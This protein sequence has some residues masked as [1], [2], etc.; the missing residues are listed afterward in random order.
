MPAK[1][2]M[3]I[4]LAPSKS[5]LSFFGTL[6]T[7]AMFVLFLA[8]GWRFA[9]SR[10]NWAIPLFGATG[11][12]LG[13]AQIMAGDSASLYFYEIT[14]RGLPVGV[15]ANPNHQACFLLMCL[16]FVAALIGQLR[17][18]W[19]S[20]DSDHA[21]AI[22][23]AAAA[24]LIL[25]GILATGSVAGY[26]ML[27]PVLA[28]CVVLAR[29]PRSSRR[30]AIAFPAIVI[31][32]T[33]AAVL[34]VAF[35]PLLDGL[36]VTSFENSDLSRLG[37]W[38]VTMKVVGDHWLAGTGLGSFEDVYRLYENPDTVTEKYVN[39][40]HNDY[41]QALVEFGLP[42]IAILLTGVVLV[43]VQF[44]RVWTRR[45]DEHRRIRRAAATALLVL[46]LHSFVDYPGR[47]P[48]IACLAATCFALLV[49]NGNSDRQ[50]KST[51]TKRPDTTSSADDRRIVI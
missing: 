14:T 27:L 24:G 3:P 39:H 19:A 46:I 35:S 26:A 10:L 49:V 8:L 28:L 9:A 48:A 38:T 1:T 29:E 43:L 6:P 13:F 47:R 2:A 42:G 21:K 22:V 5:F 4:S 34:L 41:L 12:L 45:G 51:A 44:V 23:V 16:P 20:G 37:I 18:D 36:G 50:R 25:T 17:R 11:A 30:L 15:F 32:A 40:A 33:F 7:I 31:A